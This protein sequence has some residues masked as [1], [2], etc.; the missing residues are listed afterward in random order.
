M[1]FIVA[2]VTAVNGVDKVSLGP[3]PLETT[4]AAIREKIAGRKKV[5][6]KMVVLYFEGGPFADTET[7]NDLGVNL[8]GDQINYTVLVPGGLSTFQ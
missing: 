1:S 2:E 3:L 6:A 4:G 8:A 7:L 5:D